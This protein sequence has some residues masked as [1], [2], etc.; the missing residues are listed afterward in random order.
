MTERET[1]AAAL[2]RRRRSVDAHV[3][4]DGLLCVDGDSRET[5]RDRADVTVRK[6]AWS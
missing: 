3:S 5:D 2:L 6:V 1:E 4:R